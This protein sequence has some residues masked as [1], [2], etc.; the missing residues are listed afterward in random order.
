VAEKVIVLGPFPLVL[1]KVPELLGLFVP[2]NL[3]VLIFP[4]PFKV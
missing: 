1:V 3:I 2:D 4:S